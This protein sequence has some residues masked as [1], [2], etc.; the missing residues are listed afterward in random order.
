MK[1]LCDQMA[2]IRN[3]ALSMFPQSAQYYPIVEFSW[4]KEETL[5]FTRMP[6]ADILRTGQTEKKRKANED[7]KIVVED[8]DDKQPQ[9]EPSKVLP[10]HFDEKNSVPSLAKKRKL[11]G[12]SD[13]ADKENV[14]P[15]KTSVA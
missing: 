2:A 7:V 6:Q 14:D 13:Q 11:C 15:Q 10:S 4:L 5:E 8:S 3:M 12:D 1:S 9:P